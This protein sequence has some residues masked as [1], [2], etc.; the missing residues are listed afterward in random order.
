MLGL[1]DYDILG[2]ICFLVQGDK[3]LLKEF[4]Q[5]YGFPLDTFSTE[6]LKFLKRKLMALILL[7]RYSNLDIIIRIE[8]WKNKVK[9]L[10]DLE[11]LVLP[12]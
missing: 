9:T 7:H 10:E 1:E 2:P 5:S 4:L 12:L 3:I 8:G 6:E 11:N